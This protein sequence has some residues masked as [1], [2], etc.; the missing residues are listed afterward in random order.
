MRRTAPHRSEGSTATSR[1]GAWIVFSKAV[2]EEL[3]E[4]DQYTALK[5]A[6]MVSTQHTSCRLSLQS[7]DQGI[8]EAVSRPRCG[9]V[10]TAVALATGLVT[11]EGAAI[12]LA[13]DCNTGRTV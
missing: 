7:M 13:L 6:V 3:P 12:S 8:H 10:D 4:R 5:V 11:V 2:T 9:A 1:R